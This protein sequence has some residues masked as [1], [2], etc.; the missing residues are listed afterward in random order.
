MISWSKRKSYTGCKVY[1]HY[2]IWRLH[3]A[4][5]R[6]AELYIATYVYIYMEGTWPN[7]VEQTCN[8]PTASLHYPSKL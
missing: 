8:F 6:G 1:M 5:L 4:S 2:W 7:L 3:L